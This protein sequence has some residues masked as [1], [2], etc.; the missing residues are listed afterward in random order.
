[1][2]FMEKLYRESYERLARVAFRLTGDMDQAKD[3]VQD[4]FMLALGHAEELRDHPAPEAWLIVT[5]KNLLRNEQRRLSNQEISLDT[6]L[7]VPA[8]ES[9]EPLESVL[10]TDLSP[11][12]RQVLVWR[13]QDRLD[14]REIANRLGISETGC[15][16]RVSRALERYRKRIKE[17]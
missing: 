6:L 2:D 1:M 5:L 11:E 17:K 10:P 9:A 14:Y 7:F 12:D 8:P 3:L 15:R 16:S 13:F 4:T